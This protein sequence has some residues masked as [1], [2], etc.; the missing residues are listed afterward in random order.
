MAEAPSYGTARVLDNPVQRWLLAA[1]NRESRSR[2]AAIVENRQAVSTPSERP[3]PRQ[4][5][6]G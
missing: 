1:R 2:L 5:G 4:V 6:G 3:R